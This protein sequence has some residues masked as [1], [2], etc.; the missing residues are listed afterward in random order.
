MLKSEDGNFT[1]LD[2]TRFRKSPMEVRDEVKRIAK[3]D[4]AKVR[5]WIE[6]EPGNAGKFLIQQYQRDLEEYTVRGL[7]ATGSKESYYD[8]ASAKAESGRVTLLESGW[9]IR[10]FLDELEAV[11]H[12][13]H[14][15]QADAFSKAIAVLTMKKRWGVVRSGKADDE[16]V[17][18]EPVLAQEIV[19]PDGRRLFNAATGEWEDDPA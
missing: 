10:E 11:P 9:K 15:D 13:K 2:V 7:R 19:T 16:P 1:V 12:A 8:N 14:D 3:Q 18:V 6:Q 4:G 17:L 5:I